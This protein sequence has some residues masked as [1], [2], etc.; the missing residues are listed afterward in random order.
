M[1]VSPL[2]RP[3]PDDAD[4]VIVIDA[5]SIT[6]GELEQI[7]DITGRNVVSE[8]GRGQPSAK[9]MTALVYIFKRRLDPDFTIDDA[10]NMDVMSFRIEAPSNPKEPAG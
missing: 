2:P 5:N 3:E 4:E 9:T 1:T 8:L 10:K 7:E 6:L